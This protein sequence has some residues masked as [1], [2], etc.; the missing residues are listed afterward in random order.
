MKLIRQFALVVALSTTLFSCIK[1]NNIVTSGGGNGGTGGGG[2]GG[3]GS[4]STYYIK[5]KLD[6]VARTFNANAMAIKTNLAG[7]ST[8]SIIG[9][10]ATGSLEGINISINN[11]PNVSATIGTGTYSESNTTNYLLAV[12]YNAGSTSAVW[13]AG[14]NPAPANPFEVVITSLTATEVKGTFKGDVYD[15]NGT[16]TNKK[17]F[18]EGEFN[19]KF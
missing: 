10:A 19:V 18:T 17:T 13:G 5:A 4:T 15:N 2:T 6:G 3:G 8:L 16:G 14:L 11:T 12:V 1:S 9:N 7:F